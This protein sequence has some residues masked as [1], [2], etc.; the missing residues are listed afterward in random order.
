[1][2]NIGGIVRIFIEVPGT[3]FYEMDAI[4]Y[5]MVAIYIAGWLSVL[6]VRVQQKPS[7]SS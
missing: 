5:N 1:M 6:E 7:R 2:Y 4:L 3:W